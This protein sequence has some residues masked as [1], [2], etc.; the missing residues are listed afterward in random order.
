MLAQQLGEVQCQMCSTESTLNTRE[1]RKM[2]EEKE[3]SLQT[4]L[5][6]GVDSRPANHSAH[7]VSASLLSGQT[8]QSRNCLSGL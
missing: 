4:V 6:V 8:P 1:R 3:S 5:I 7:L 2:A